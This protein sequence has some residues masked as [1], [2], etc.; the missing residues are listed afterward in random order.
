[1][2][3]EKWKLG[4]IVASGGTGR[5]YRALN[6]MTGCLCALKKVHL[7]EMNIEDCRN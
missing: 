4:K 1:M 7:K 6:S 3:R 2:G 5:V